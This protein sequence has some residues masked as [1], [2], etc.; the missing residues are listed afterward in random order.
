MTAT[1]ARTRPGPSPLQRLG[2]A[3]PYLLLAPGLIYLLLFYVLPSIQMFTYSISKG[4]LETGFTIT[5]SLDAYVESIN[6]FGKQSKRKT[7][8]L[9]S[10]TPTE[11]SNSASAA[12]R[13]F[14]EAAAKFHSRSNRVSPVIA[15]R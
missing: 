13:A 5:F 6:K 15:S 4:S 2:R 11:Q 8:P 3:T 12:R 10:C 7:G 9:L 1:T 14:S